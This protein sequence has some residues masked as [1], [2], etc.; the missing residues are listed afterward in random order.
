[1][2]LRRAVLWFAIAEPVV[3]VV[4]AEPEAAPLQLEGAAARRSHT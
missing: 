2:S 3:C 1:M 4:D